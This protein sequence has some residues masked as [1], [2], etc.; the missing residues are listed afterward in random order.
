M[1]T[2]AVSDGRFPSVEV[3]IAETTA[4]IVHTVI[5]VAYCLY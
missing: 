1:N 3:A 2:Q 5:H 4:V